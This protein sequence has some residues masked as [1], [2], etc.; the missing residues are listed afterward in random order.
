MKYLVVKIEPRG[1][2]HTLAL[3]KA[4]IKEA[5]ILDRTLVITQA[6]LPGRH[7]FYFGEKL[8][9]NF[10]DY[11]NL[12]KTSIYKMDKN[13]RQ[14]C[15]FHYI[16]AEN[17]NLKSYADNQIV[18][19]Q[20]EELLPTHNTCEVIIRKIE[21]R[22]FT[23]RPR[24]TSYVVRFEPADK[25]NQITDQVLNAMGTSLAQ[26]RELNSIFQGVDFSANR[27]NYATPMP[28]GLPAYYACLHVRFNDAPYMYDLKHALKPKN[29]CAVLERAIPKSSRLYIMSDINNPNYFDFLK[30]DYQIYQYHDFPMLKRLVSGED[31]TPVDNAMLYSVEK[32]ILQYANRKIIPFRD[33]LYNNYIVYT[34]V[35]YN[36]LI[37]RIIQ[38]KNLI[39][40]SN[41]SLKFPKMYSL[42][43]NGK[44]F[45]IRKMYSLYKSRFQ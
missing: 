22:A 12:D 29:I 37:W 43:R 26:V 27:D 35:I 17:F 38:S 33:E 9:I 10:D 45:I 42:Y 4:A 44:D 13:G 8:P 36:P 16:K 1:L 28:T 25:V 41:L 21:S 7:N 30:K 23:W 39:N 40:K 34:G 6:Y 20:E 11:I 19:L 14:E 32:N 24:F 2:D 5:V 18:E 15:P 31:G 3:L